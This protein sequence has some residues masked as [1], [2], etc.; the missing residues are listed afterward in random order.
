MPVIETERDDIRALEGLH[1]FHFAMSNC[2]QRVRLSLEEKGVSWTSHHIDLS[3]CEN[4]T[5]EF[6]AIN[7]KGVVPVLIHDGRTI[8]E[9]NDII[10]YVDEYFDGPSLSPDNDTDVAYFEESLQ[11]SSDF[12]P[13]LKLLTH[14]YLFKPVRRMNERQLEEYAAGTKNPELVSFMREFS[15][16]EGF[17]RSRILGAVAQVEDILSLL[18]S[19]LA[20]KPWLT[21]R[22]FG[23]TDISWVV[24]IYR[25]RH[26]HYPLSSYS[27]VSDWLKRT[28]LRP[29][30]NVAITAYESRKMTVVFRLYS[31]IRYLKRTS[32][33][34]SLKEVRVVSEAS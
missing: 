29:A 21:G 13:A 1:L 3:K 12:Q 14:E 26:M 16:P 5:P 4:A 33:S 2:S 23:L 8:V 18:E 31:A 6:V 27:L 19:R 7:P 11:R 32:V 15:S 34:Q 20:K 9:S 10:R 24:N 17:S 25:L 28:R 30:F 22:H